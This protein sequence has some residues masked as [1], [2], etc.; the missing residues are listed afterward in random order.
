MKVNSVK[1]GTKRGENLVIIL[2]DINLIKTLGIGNAYTA[3][4]F[5]EATHRV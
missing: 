2:L 1:K 5:E 3:E 4:H